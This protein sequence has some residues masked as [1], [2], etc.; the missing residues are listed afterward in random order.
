[1]LIWL[2]AFIG[3]YAHNVSGTIYTEHENN[4]ITM[5]TNFINNIANNNGS[6]VY[7]KDI[8]IFLIIV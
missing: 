3:N 8:L 5:S 2:T 6:I 7:N 1:M 4:F